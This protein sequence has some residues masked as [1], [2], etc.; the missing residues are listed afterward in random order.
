[1]KNNVIAGDLQMNY[2]LILDIVLEQMYNK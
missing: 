1:M 2:Q